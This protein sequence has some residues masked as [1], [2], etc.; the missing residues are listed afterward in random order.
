[1]NWWKRS[2]LGIRPNEPLRRHTTF[3]IGGPAQFFAC[4][5]D[6]AALAAL[7]AACRS[8]ALAVRVIGAGSNLL[9]SDRGVAG[10]V[11]SLAGA[12]FRRIQ[13]RG[14]RVS[15]GAG[16]PLAQLVAYC[17]RRGLSGA[18]FLCG[19]PGTLGGALVMNA[20]ISERRKGRQRQ[21]WIGDLVESVEVM[22]YNGAVRRLAGADLSWAYRRSNLGGM[23][24]L[25]ARLRLKRS[26]DA[27]AVPAAVAAY[28]RKRAGTQDTAGRSAGCVFKNPA[29]D[30]P[31]GKLI[32]LCGAKGL[33]SG[34]AMV[35]GRHANFIVARPGAS[36]ADVR[37]LMRLVQQRVK[38]KFAVSLEPEIE[39]WP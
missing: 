22:D 14:V 28:R 16:L 11:I 8:R 39:L 19:I 1:M 25:S 5:S 4:P 35:S 18:E 13:R 6:R 34:K 32:D 20:G 3:G 9:V 23:V 30:M 12:E 38:K 26:A 10:M 27:Q 31:A 33:R 15:A 37:R 7:L 17:S 36:A 21:R 24:V 2:N 29:A